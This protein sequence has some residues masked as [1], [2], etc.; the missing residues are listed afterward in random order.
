MCVC[1]CV[2]ERERET[3][4]RRGRKRQTR[5]TN[6]RKKEWPGNYGHLFKMY[7]FDG[8][9]DEGGKLPRFS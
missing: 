2:R 8:R 5:K 6:K 4:V 7:S 3:I 9:I 1:V